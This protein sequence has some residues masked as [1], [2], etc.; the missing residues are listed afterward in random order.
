MNRNREEN[1]R[2]ANVHGEKRTRLYRVWCAM[3]ERC[4]NPHN[5][6]FSRYGGRGIC[7][8]QEWNDYRVFREW[9]VANGY[10]ETLTIDRINQNGPYSPSNCRFV[11]VAE[12]NRNYSR[13]KQITYQ[14]TTMCL[15]DWA[16]TLG[17][18][19]STLA[20]RLKSGLCLE[21]A[22]MKKDRRTK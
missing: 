12:Q 4:S 3:R 17:I 5:K 19:K 6:R 20:L 16:K 18:N 14:G 22:F 11:T 21:E 8:C 13:N 1:G 9:A 10:G 2:F 15:T 7:V